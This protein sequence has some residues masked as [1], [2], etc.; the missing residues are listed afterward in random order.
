[1]LMNIYILQWIPLNSIYYRSICNIHTW[2]EEGTKSHSSTFLWAFGGSGFLMTQRR[3]WEMTHGDKLD[4]AG[5]GWI[6][7]LL[8]THCWIKPHFA[9]SV[10]H[11]VGKIKQSSLCS[12]DKVAQVSCEF[13]TSKN[14][15]FSLK[16]RQVHPA[17]CSW[18]AFSL[19]PG[20]L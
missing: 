5:L 2:G 11:T 19:L 14:L 20:L 18:P 13:Q 9:H 12:Q 6:L 3:G 7:T 4:W 17:S 16:R 1:M 10:Q 15:I 8:W